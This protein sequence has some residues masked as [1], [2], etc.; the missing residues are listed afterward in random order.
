MMVV[1][2]MKID[3]ADTTEDLHSVLYQEVLNGNGI[4]LSEA[5]PSI[6]LLFKLREAFN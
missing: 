3:F 6:E 4:D 2:G 1:D 5:R